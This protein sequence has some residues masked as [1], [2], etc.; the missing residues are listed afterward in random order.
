MKT[1]GLCSAIRYKDTES[2]RRQLSSGPLSWTWRW[3]SLAR[4]L[5]F[6]V[7]SP[8]VTA[9]EAGSAGFV[10][11]LLDAGAPVD[12]VD[13]RKITPL[14]LASET[15]KVEIARAL[16]L[17][18]A[19]VNRQSSGTLPICLAAYYGH[20]LSVHLL[21]EHGARPDDVLK[22]SISSLIR[23]RGDVLR[24]LITAGGLAPSEITSLL[25]DGRAL[26]DVSSVKSPVSPEESPQKKDG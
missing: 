14:A 21:L 11:L 5:G 10:R 2:V 1:E 4:F 18:G 23:I 13:Y 24:S 20:L 22:G 26:G 3:I 19:D 12:Q 25:E 6:R 7:E 17:A 9:V 16:I 15:G 8:L